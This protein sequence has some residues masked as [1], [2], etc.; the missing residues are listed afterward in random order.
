MIPTAIRRRRPW[1][2]PTIIV[3][4]V[5]VYLMWNGMADPEYMQRNFLCSWTRVEAGMYW[6]LL[7]TVFSHNMLWHIFINMF[8]LSSFGSFL[9][10]RLGSRRFLWLYLIAGISA[11]IVHCLTSAFLLNSPELPALGASG[12]V[13]GIVATF[14]VLQP[15]ARILL[16]GIIPLPALVGVALFVGLDLWG[17]V[18]Q[19]QGGGLP[20][21][22]GAHLGG[23]F[24]GI[25]YGLLQKNSRR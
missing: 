18:A 7:T 15:Q 25:L 5:I 4:N 3:I 19:T 10:S 8:V 22:H 17:L 16:F 20:L 13:A 14:A 1:V 23:A 21:G 2:T 12:A 24:V 11:S 6:T 9:E